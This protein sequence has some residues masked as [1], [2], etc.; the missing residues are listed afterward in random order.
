MDIYYRYKP[1]KTVVFLVDASS[2]NLSSS[3]KRIAIVDGDGVIWPA[4]NRALSEAER[5]EIEEWVVDVK[6]KLDDGEGAEC[7]RVMQLAADLAKEM[8]ALTGSSL[9][10]YQRKQLIFSLHDVKRNLLR[11]LSPDHN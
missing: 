2:K 3:L 5:A 11:A 8:Q 4:S 7:T 10:D 6:S 9:N 1:K